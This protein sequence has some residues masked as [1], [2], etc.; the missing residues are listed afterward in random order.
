MTSALLN[1]PLDIALDLKEEILLKNFSFKLSIE[2]L[3]LLTFSLTY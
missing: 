3:I 2:I 1:Q